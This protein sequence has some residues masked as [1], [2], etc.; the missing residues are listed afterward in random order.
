MPRHCTLL[1]VG[2]ALFGVAVFVLRPHPIISVLDA[3]PLLHVAFYLALG[4]LSAVLVFRRQ[5]DIF[6]DP[7]GKAVL[8][9]GC[10]TGFGYSLAQRLDEMGYQVFAGC[11]APDREGAL[12]LASTSSQR[13]RVVPL[14]VTDDW[15]VQQ[16]LTTVTQH[17]EEGALWAVI[18]NAGIAT[19]TEIEWCSVDQ[20]QRLLDVNVLGVVRVTKAFLPLLRQS[21]GRVIN[22]ASLAGRFTIPA[23]AAYSMSKKAC[24]AFSDALRMEMKKFDVSVV[25]IEPGLYR[26]PITQEEYLINSNRKSW[27]ETPSAIKDDYGEEY[28]AAFLQNMTHQMK[29]ARPNVHEVVDLM[30]TAVCVEK[31]RHRYVPYWR[32]YLR[33]L[34]L[35]NC[36]ALVTDRIFQGMSVKVP[37]SAKTRN[38]KSSS[39]ST[40]KSA[41]PVSATP[42]T[43]DRSVFSDTPKTVPNGQVTS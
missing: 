21:C 11:L 24:I 40:P 14:D 10:D 27:A 28:F 3:V 26:T 43:P 31:P 37:P 41:T 18:N 23:F 25:T 35:G 2:V 17:C 1:G 36:P 12:Q 6:V 16:A 13:L 5:P 8:I 7:A 34:V 32:S 38:S 33:S 22:V 39:S 42:S 4:A 29:R 30:V 9:T 19:F 20:F 15:Q